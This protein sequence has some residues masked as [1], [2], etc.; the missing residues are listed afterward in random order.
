MVALAV[1]AIALVALLGLHN[2][3]IALVA[4]DQE[5]TYA[6]LLAR[7]QIAVM[8]LVEGFPELGTDSGEFDDFPDYKWEREVQETDFPDLREVHL[9]I[10]WDDRPG[11][12]YELHYF[13]RDH[14]EPTP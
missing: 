14:R 11:D 3:N 2:R 5:R 6:T 9:R 13:A 4:R 8:E 12:R 1:V 7:Q 10:T